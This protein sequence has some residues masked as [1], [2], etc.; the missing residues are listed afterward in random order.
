MLTKLRMLMLKIWIWFFDQLNYRAR[1]AS[2]ICM[3]F[4]SILGQAKAKPVLVY[5][6]DTQAAQ[7]VAYNYVVILA[8]L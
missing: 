1:L 2:M 8:N 7:S 5:V 4:K 6:A 3:S